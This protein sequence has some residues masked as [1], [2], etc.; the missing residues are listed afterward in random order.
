M[1]F[2]SEMS[3]INSCIVANAGNSYPSRISQIG[4]WLKSLAV[5]VALGMVLVSGALFSHH[6]QAIDLKGFSYAHPNP[7][8]NNPLPYP[9]IY[10]SQKLACEVGFYVQWPQWQGIFQPV[11]TGTGCD[12]FCIGN[13]T[14]QCNSVSLIHAGVTAWRC[15]AGSELR[16]QTPPNEGYVCDANVI[17]PSKAV[18]PEACPTGNCN[19]SVRS[20]PIGNPINPATGN[21]YEVVR[22]YTS[23]GPFPIRWERTYNSENKGIQSDLAILDRHRWSYRYQSAL[24]GTVSTSTLYPSTF[25]AR[26]PDG[27]TL[28]FSQPQRTVAPFNVWSDPFT[29]DANIPDRLATVMNPSVPTDPLGWNYTVASDDSVEF[30]DTVGRLVS[31]K[32]RAGLTQTM[33]YSTAATPTTVAPAAGYLI[34]V[35][36]PFGRSI[37]ITYDSASRTKTVTDFAGGVITYQYTSA[38]SKSIASITYQDGAVR[39]YHYEDT[40]NP[41]LLTGITDENGSRFATWA[42]DASRRAISSTHAGGADSTTVVYNANGSSLVTRALGAANTYGFQAKYGVPRN[43]SVT[44]SVCPTC[45][46]NSATVDTFGNITSRVDWNG[47]RTNFTWDTARILQTQ[48]VEGLTAAGAITPQTRTITTEWHGNTAVRLVKRIAEPLRITTFVYHG[49]SGTT[50]GASWALCTKTVQATTDATGASGF[51]ATVTGTPRTWN[52]TYNS[53][54]LVLTANGPRTD[55]TDTTTYTYYANNDTDLGKRGNVATITNALGHVTSITA[56]NLHGQPLTV[57]DPNGLTTTLAYD[58][59]QRLTS[60]SVG[61]ETTTYT[62]DNAGQLTKVTLPDTSFL[63]YTYD[64]AHRLTQIADNLGNKIVYT[65]DAMGNRT[66]EEVRDPANALAQTRSRVYSSLNRLSQEIGATGQTTTYAYDNQGNVTSVTDP[67]SRV[68]TNQ[69]DALNR[70]VQITA[71]GTTVTKYAYNGLDQ[72]TQVTDPRNLV[73]GYTVNGLGNLTQ[74]SSPDTGATVNTYDAAGNLLTQTD[75]KGQVTTYTYDAINR[76][77]S[78][79]FNDGS[80]Q[81]YAYDQGANGLGRLTQIAELDPALTETARIDYAYDQKG[82]VLSETRTVN[83]VAYVTAYSYDASGRMNGVTY[84]SGR[85]MAYTFDALGRVNQVT[86]M[87]PASQGGATQVVAQNIQYHPFGGAK[88]W[89][90]GNG[91]IVARTID[92]DGRIA[93]YTLGNSTYSVAFDAASRITGIAE[94]GNP[95]NANTYGYDNLDRLT[96]AILPSNTLGYG[97]DAVGNRTS[98]TIGA[99]T[100][101]LAYSATS[102]RLASITPAS[103]PVKTYAFDANGSTTNDGVNQFAY[104]S[105]GRMVQA[106]TTAGSTGYQVNA[107]GQRIRKTNAGTDTVYV[108]DTQGRLIAE[109]DPGGVTRREYLYLNDIPLAVIQ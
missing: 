61:G 73:T 96:S 64:A 108:Y 92:Q 46:P 28:A 87:A 9:P 82:R 43:N 18:G 1:V 66:Q 91:Q 34:G 52:Y 40:A 17:N 75:A 50:C 65:L 55:L 16:P 41:D 44:G 35:T 102:N 100:E 42:Y 15:N 22:D 8:F 107:L 48:R 103:G 77:T 109:A 45:G 39:T 63:Q 72:L 32:N 51:A 31:I 26:R 105:R 10:P 25:Y 33:T 47:N 49:D 53:N 69:Y 4:S 5:A 78:I 93:A 89:T 106:T 59:R 58:A 13:F 57:V 85:S 19:D 90:L 97:Y 36:D 99:T 27:R 38:T 62:Y 71:P 94:T 11:W 86:T 54:G 79:T 29:A 76:V 56:Y 74:Q 23:S 37:S 104:D 88:S 3:Q 60:R 12:Y 30:Y 95:G 98:K 6:S 81:N 14:S 20:E 70:L 84:P 68:T 24:S 67:L 83:A 2:A 7:I 101:T 21:K 80:K